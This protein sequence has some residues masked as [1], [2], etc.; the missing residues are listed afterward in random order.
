MRDSGIVHALLRL[1][2]YD[3]LLS[4][5]VIGASWEGFVIEN[6]L[7]VAGWGTD[8]SFYRSRGG[9]E[10]DLVLSWRDGR[11]WIVEVKRSA[12]TKLR[13]GFTAAWEDVKPERGFVVYAGAE[14]YRIRRDV[15]AIGLVELCREVAAL[16]G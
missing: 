13:R 14:R 5:P 6:L 1:P 4:H 11:R 7:N 12:A 8:A 10:A 16:A 2:T 3:D 9:A 15:E